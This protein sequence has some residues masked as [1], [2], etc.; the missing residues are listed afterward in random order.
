MKINKNLKAVFTYLIII[1]LTSAV[2]IFLQNGSDKSIKNNGSTNNPLSQVKPADESPIIELSES[3][4]NKSG[5][6]TV[7]LTQTLHQTQITS[8]G[9]VVPIQDLS[10]D[11]ENYESDK[12]QFAKAEENLIISRQNFERTKSLYAR[13]LASEQDF[14]SSQAAFLSDKAD[15]TSAESKLNSLKSSLIEQWGNGISK[16]IFNGSPELQHLLSLNNVL[17]QISLPANRMNIKIP[18]KILIQPS[19]EN[20]TIIS[21]RFVSSGRIANPQ[22]Q[23]RTLY[24]VASNA[25]LNTGLNVKAYLSSGK[26]LTGVIVPS[27]SI[28]WYQGKAWIYAEKFP[29]KFIRVEVDVSNPV[30]NGF[31]VTE[32]EG[33]IKAGIIVVKNGAQLLLSEE[34][35]PAQGSQSGGVDND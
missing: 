23:T 6:T 33:I 31:F 7:K 17:I 2:W 22:F 10:K 27:S 9:T 34:L 13:K 25:S 15:K 8:Y 3:E 35:T 32:D 11:I 18:D 30:G 16:W 24:Y 4:L 21:C 19:S 5:I 12:A 29:N 26:K 1:L 20:G 28:V 14:Q